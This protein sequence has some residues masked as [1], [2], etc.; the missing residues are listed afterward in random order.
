MADTVGEKLWEP[1]C[2][3]WNFGATRV[4]QKLV[5][6]LPPVQKLLASVPGEEV[7]RDK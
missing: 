7:G 2:A 5:E 3:F 4:F 1:G 6:R